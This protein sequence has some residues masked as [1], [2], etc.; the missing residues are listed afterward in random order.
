MYGRYPTLGIDRTGFTNPDMS[1]NIMIPTTAVYQLASTL[2]RWFGVS[3]AQLA[4]I[5]PNLT[6]FPTSNLGFMG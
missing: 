3:D 6:N 5:F 2:G 4:T 1:G